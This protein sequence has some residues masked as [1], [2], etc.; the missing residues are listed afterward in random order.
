[1]KVYVKIE[2]ISCSHC[3][4]TIET[5]L[6]KEKNIIKVEFQKNIVIIEYVG[7][8]EKKKI[9]KLINSLGY[10]T[11][12][13]YIS[14]DISLLS[15]KVKPVEIIIILLIIILV[16][17]LLNKIIGFNIFNVIPTID[18]NITYGMLFVTGLLTSIHCVSMCGAINLLTVINKTTKR[19][20]KNPILYNL[21]RLI[22]YTAL[23]GIVGLIGSV[24]TVN[25][26]VTG[27]IILLAAIVMFL[28]ALAMLGLIPLKKLKLI[29]HKTV[30]ANPL[31]IGLLNGLMPCGPLQAMQVYALST[32]SP[33]KG[34]IS[35]FLFCLG[36][37]PLM[38]GTGLFLNKLTGK[39]KIIVNKI[40]TCLI[41]ILSVVMLN[42]ALLYLN[43][44]LFKNN[45]DSTYQKAILKE[46]YQEVK[47]NVSY[48][49]YQDIIIQKDIPVKLII[50]VDED[51]LTGCNNEIYLAKYK[52][53][54]KLKVGD[55]I[56]EFTPT[57]EETLT[58]TC[59]MN[60]IKNNIKVIDN[61]KYFERKS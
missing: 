35:M 58:Y 46:T 13:S 54:K 14:D 34:A 12:E 48:G 51:K 56:I 16:F 5:N 50:H 59:Y 57:K 7:K 53:K 23:G 10:L 19:S 28:M 33:I 32:G 37:I 6:L 30:T 49:N 18:E 47:I 36:T 52:I 4:D 9:I 15:D 61:K 27:I 43:I 20:Y 44:D 60:M 24:L 39:W 29:R 26:T 31:I 45:D 42:Q 1:M 3:L 55:N 2:G 40:A 22:S 8:L 17:Y 41:L 21:G 38:L 11:Q 25:K